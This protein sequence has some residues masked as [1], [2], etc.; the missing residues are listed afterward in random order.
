MLNPTQVHPLAAHP[1]T[2]APALAVTKQFIHGRT[3]L[4]CR[5]QLSW[6]A[7]RKAVRQLG[8]VPG[9]IRSSA[10][11]S[12]T[13]KSTATVKAVVTVTPPTSG[14]FYEIGINRGLD[15]ITDLMG[16]TLLLELV[17]SELDPSK[18]LYLFQK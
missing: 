7:P 16:K 9:S 1:H 4:P 13:E 15:D 5:R 10:V 14:A 2:L 11:A 12:V 18:Q 3:V 8:F 17:S 6:T